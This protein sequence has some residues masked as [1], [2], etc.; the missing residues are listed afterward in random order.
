MTAIDIAVATDFADRGV[1]VRLGIVTAA[2]A[3][4]PA[5]PALAAALD[6]VVAGLPARLAGAPVS[7]VPAVAAT[8][9]AY[10]ALG[11]DPARYR[12]AAEALMRRVAQGKGL[13]RVNNV[14]DVNNLISLRTGF[15]IGTYD[16]DR[17]APPVVFRRAGAGET[18]HGIGRGPLNLEGL[19]VFC[20]A[21]GPFGSPTSD[22]E[23]TMVTG[24]ARRV[25]MVIIGFGDA[26]GLNPG[27]STDLDRTVDQAAALLAAHCGC[28]AT[29]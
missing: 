11:K 28:P 22:S 9:H 25:L 29:A 27:L 5:G 6:E 10:R 26:A 23:R 12:P 17:L 13:Y 3:V 4:A 20:D 2:V 18:Y 21:R 24:A 14:V 7:Q 15:S 8:R 16:L 19:P 1:A